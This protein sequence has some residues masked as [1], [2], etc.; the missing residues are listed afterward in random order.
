VRSKVPEHLFAGFLALAAFFGAA[1]HVLVALELLAFGGALLASLFAGFADQAAERA[2]TRNHLGRCRAEVGAVLARLQRLIVVL[3]AFCQH[4]GAM[5][6]A[7]VTF[8]LTVIASV[9]ALHK[10]AVLA[11]RVVFVVLLSGY[12]RL[13][14]QGRC[15][16]QSESAKFASSYHD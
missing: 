5:V 12:R 9:G 3:F 10:R 4:A 7:R 11:M 15:R 8:A 6:C 1:G 13:E 16:R 2:V 14:S